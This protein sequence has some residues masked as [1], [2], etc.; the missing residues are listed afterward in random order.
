[1]KINKQVT[2]IRFFT[3]VFITSFFGCD[4]LVEIYTIHKSTIKIAVPT[5]YK[6]SYIIKTELVKKNDSFNK[7][8]LDSISKPY[9]IDELD[10]MLISN[11]EY[12]Y[13]PAFSQS[14]NNPSETILCKA[15]TM[16]YQQLIN[17]RDDDFFAYTFYIYIYDRDSENKPEILEF[18]FSLPHRGKES[19]NFRVE[20]KKLGT[21]E[22]PANIEVWIPFY[23]NLT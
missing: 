23:T 14:K 13:V 7:K 15:S 20:S 2:L 16:Y 21:S 12:E 17:D 11:P 8:S 5:V 18:P 22:N 4:A 19:F 10:E 6:N 3:I 1:M 9:T